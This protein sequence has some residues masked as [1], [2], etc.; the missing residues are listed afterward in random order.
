[1]LPAFLL[2]VDRL[3]LLPVDP[4]IFAE[5]DDV[6]LAGDSAELV[7]LARVGVDQ[8]YGRFARADA[9]VDDRLLAGRVISDHAPAGLEE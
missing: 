7:V 2:S 9:L 4:R 6:F 8:T 1:M 5:P 3:Y